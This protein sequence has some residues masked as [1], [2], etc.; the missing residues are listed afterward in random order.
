L[1]P[2]R[3]LHHPHGTEEGAQETP[4]LSASDE[5]VP[6]QVKKTKQGP[7][8]CTIIGQSVPH[9]LGLVL[10]VE[11]VQRCNASHKLI[12]TQFA[13]KGKKGDQRDNTLT[14]AHLPF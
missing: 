14:I 13:W 1:G 7:H 4:Q 6:I 8:T 3:S 10:L 5:A 2:L 9:S 12:Q 11:N